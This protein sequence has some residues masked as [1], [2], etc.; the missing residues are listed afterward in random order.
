M[1]RRWIESAKSLDLIFPSESH[2]LSQETESEKQWKQMVAEAV[3]AYTCV[4]TWIVISGVVILFNKWILS[5][6]GFHYPILL[7]MWHMLFCSV[8]AQVTI[9]TDVVSHLSLAVT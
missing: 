5:V 7:T 4:G 8:A 9:A 1:R 6:Y 2:W 3:T